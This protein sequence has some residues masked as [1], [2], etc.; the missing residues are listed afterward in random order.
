MNIAVWGTK[1]EAIYMA[2]ILES[3][4]QDEIICFVDNDEKQWGKC[5]C[6]KPVYP[7]SHLKQLYLKKVDAIVL[8]IRNG[9]NIACILEQLKRE[10]ID[11]IG[12]LKPSA[13]DFDKEIS[14]DK[15]SEQIVWLENLKKPL[16]PYLQII[17]IKTCNLNCKGCTHFANLYN[18]KPDNNI[19]EI[20]ELKEDIQYFSDNTEVFRLRLLGGEPLLYSELVDAMEITHKC[21]PNTDIRIVTNGLLLLKVPNKLLQ[22]ISTNKIGLDI[23]PYKPTIKIKERII[24]RLNNFNIDYC[25][26]GIKDGCIE[27]FEK[28]LDING[29]NKPQKSMNVC[30]A[31][32]CLTL[33]NGKL[34]K[35]PFEVF[36]SKYF[37]Y[38]SLKYCNYEGGIDKCDIKWDLIVHDLYMNPIELCKYCSD[39]IKTFSWSNTLT[40][41]YSDWTV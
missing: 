16:L 32:Q 27:T 1:K 25:F 37:D 31:K 18:K 41:N 15:N 40:P 21:F 4:Q 19:Y 11:K 24:E 17:L 23:S 35:C 2:N 34:Y 13:Y 20:A 28:N 38:F 36:A 33:L 5:I 14:L 8:A 10:K 6:G 9:Y 12:L 30:H 3:N 7:L 22:S 26:E 29:Q 39:T